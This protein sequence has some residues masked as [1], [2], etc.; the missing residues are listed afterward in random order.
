M[1]SRGLGVEVSALRLQG[2]YLGGNG[3]YFAVKCVG[4]SRAAI[5]GIM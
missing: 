4:D 5:V 1:L 3:C 2:I